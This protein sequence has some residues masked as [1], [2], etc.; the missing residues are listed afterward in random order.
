MAY[1]D[2]TISVLSQQFSLTIDETS[3]LFTDVP[4]AALRSEFQARLDIMVPLALT[5]STE[6]ARSE[7]IIAP[8]LFELWLLHNREI[9]LLSG[10]EFNI[11]EAQGL[12]GVCDYIITRSPEQ[13]FVKAPVLMVAEAKNEDMK[14]GYAQCMAEMIAAQRLTSG[15]AL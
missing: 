14:R 4:E 3:D 7:F 11:D 13:L 9:G 5:T 1:S 6:K 10:V 8:I 2:F 12:K 15:K